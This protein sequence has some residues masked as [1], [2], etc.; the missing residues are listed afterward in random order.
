MAL[1]IQEEVLG[2]VEHGFGNL[3]GGSISSVPPVLLF[4]TSHPDLIDSP[5][6]Q[7]HM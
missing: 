6:Q 4:V 1:R 7:C 5:N 2:M 3:L